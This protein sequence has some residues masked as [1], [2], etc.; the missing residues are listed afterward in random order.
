[1]GGEAK[2]AQRPSIFEI[3]AQEEMRGMVR[4]ALRY[5]LVKYATRYP[6][7]LLRAAQHFDETYG[8]L[9][10]LLERHH[11]REWGASF[12]ENFY[13]LRRSRPAP[14]GTVRN[15]ESKD[16][17]RSLLFLILVPYL[18]HRLDEAYEDEASRSTLGLPA[19]SETSRANEPTWRRQCRRLLRATWPTIHLIIHGSV[20]V[21]TLAYAF[22]LT[23]F[24]S[25]WYHLT[26]QY[27]RR[28][29]AEDLQADE[30]RIK[31]R[32][33]ART[34]ALSRLPFLPRTLKRIGYLLQGAMGFLRV[35]L[36]MGVF[37]LRFL[38]W[39]YASD[40]SRALSTRP[41]P[42]PPS[43]L[44]PA[45]SSDE[46]TEGLHV[47]LPEDP[48]TCPLCQKPRVNPAAL[49]SGYVFCYPCIWKWVEDRATCPIT[50]TPT[51]PEAIRK[52]Y[53]SSSAN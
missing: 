35:A 37:F 32:A 1:M 43:P 10:L 14:D 48:K 26:G 6:R 17:R 22:Q 24:P 47:P 31:E 38:E 46:D 2:L 15:L 49:P 23:D 3:V 21:Y 13:G 12:S 34:L 33:L 53:L 19:G 25:L 7:Y 39:W 20:P 50:Q 41:I 30:T 40:Y 45:S 16:I 5:I 18:T 36:P 11:L 4:R 27:L 9:L 8:L 29:G 52:L 28:A 44:L 51:Q 42:P